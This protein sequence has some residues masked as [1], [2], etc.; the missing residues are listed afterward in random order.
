[1]GAQN[2][3]ASHASRQLRG[4]GLSPL[5]GAPRGREGLTVRQLGTYEQATV[6]VTGWYPRE[7]SDLVRQIYSQCR[8]ILGERWV[9]VAGTVDVADSSFQITIKEN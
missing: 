5:P 6:V 3:L 4:A 9:L 1:M 8:Q 2:T 7:D